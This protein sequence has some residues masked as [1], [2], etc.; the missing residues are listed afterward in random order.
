MGFY[1]VPASSEGFNNF[2]I[3]TQDLVGRTA[4]RQYRC[5]QINN[6]EFLYV[7][8]FNPVSNVAFNFTLEN[9]KKKLVSKITSRIKWNPEDSTY[10]YV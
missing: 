7:N 4:W 5:V 10:T 6:N 2:S 3:P 9:F 1:V 8:S